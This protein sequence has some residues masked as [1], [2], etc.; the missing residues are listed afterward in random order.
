M[1]WQAGFVMSRVGDIPEVGETVDI[2]GQRFTVLE[3]DGRRVARL[4][5][6]PLQDPQL[7]SDEPASPP[8]P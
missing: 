5:V 3:L 4:A 2:E 6:T 1:E 8:A 7:T